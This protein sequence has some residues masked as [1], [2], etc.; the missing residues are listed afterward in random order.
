[1][2]KSEIKKAASLGH[3]KYRKKHR[4]FLVEGIHPVSELLRSKWSVESV[5]IQY[6]SEEDVEIQLIQQ[7]AASRGLKIHRLNRKTFDQIA[8]TESPQGIMAIADIPK[9][10]L[11]S[12]KAQKRILVADRISDPGNMGTI[13][14]S[15]LAFGFGG[16]CAIAGTTDIFGPKAV[17]ATQ[18]ALFSV[19]VAEHSSPEEIRE[20]LKGTHKLYALAP[21]GGRGIGNVTLSSRIALVVGSESVGVSDALLALADERL[22]IPMP[23]PVESLNAAV[24]ASIAMYEL[25]RRP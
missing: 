7:L 14:R 11:A 19:R 10:D 3:T 23:G 22:T 20:H 13:I 1:M 18:G 25:S 6:E 5:L 24:S 15:A 4:Q 2:T 12:L 17:R 21:R 16:V 8:A 9:R